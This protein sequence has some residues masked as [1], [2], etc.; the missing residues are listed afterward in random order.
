MNWCPQGIYLMLWLQMRKH[1]LAT[2]A[3]SCLFSLSLP[4]SIHSLPSGM[5]RYYWRAVTFSS[6]MCILRTCTQQIEITFSIFKMYENHSRKLNKWICTIHHQH[7]HSCSA[8]WCDIFS[9]FFFSLRAQTFI[10]TFCVCVCVLS[11]FILFVLVFSVEIL[12][13]VQMTK[14][15]N[16]VR[17]CFF[18]L[19]FIC[20]NLHR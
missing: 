10:R 4:I 19:F 1:F 15:P 6:Y 8:F 20:P 18:A 9:I 5:G 17:V 2:S 7:Q 13:I 12:S 14:R 16:C 11:A 3:A